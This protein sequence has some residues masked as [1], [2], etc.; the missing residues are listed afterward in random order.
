MIAEKTL[1]SSDFEIFE[2]LLDITKVFDAVNHQILFKHLSKILVPK[3]LHLLRLLTNNMKL[4][5]W[6]GSKFCEAFTTIIGIMQGDY[7]SAALF[8]FY[9]EKST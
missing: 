8:I 4:K 7:L 6:V 5:V 1:T 3:E 9:L 2:P